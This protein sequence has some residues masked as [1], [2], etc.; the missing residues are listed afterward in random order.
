MSIHRSLASRGAL[1]R[2]RNVFTREERCKALTLLGKWN[3]AE[4]SIFGLPK[5]RTHMKAA[6]KKAAKKEGDAAAPAAGAPG[7]GGAAPAAGAKGAAPA[8][9]AP[10][11]KGGDKKGAAK[12]AAK[13]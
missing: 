13:K 9:A 8:A 11:A 6:K 10:A 4:S 7:A 3:E 12:P 5:V 1:T 2:T